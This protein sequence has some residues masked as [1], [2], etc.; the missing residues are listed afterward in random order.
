MSKIDPIRLEVMKNAFDAIADEMALMLMRA[1]YSP[2]VRDSMDYSTAIC[3]AQGQTL[4]QGVTT[5]M[6]LGSFYDAMQHLM[7][8]YEGD[9][10]PGDVFIGNDPYAAAG[11]HLPDIYIVEPIFFEGRLVAWTTTLAHHADVGGIVPGSNA[12]GAVEIYQEGLRLPFLKLYN[13]G[14]MNTAIWEILALNVR[15]PEMV[16]GDLRAQMAASKAGRKSFGE[17]VARYGIDE[18]LACAEELH[19]YAERLGRAEIRDLPNGEYHFT[20]HIDGL[21][22]TPEPIVIQIALTIHD[23]TISVD[24][25][26]SSPQVK[27]GV[28]TP[29]PFTKASVYT[30]LRSIMLSDIPNCHGFE[31]VVTV[32]APK[33]TVVNSVHPA[34]CG[35]RG[36]TGYRV[37]DGMFG[38][39]AQVVPDRVTADGMGGSTVPTFAGWHDGQAFV[40][41]ETVMGTWGASSAHDGQVGVP[42][43]GA[44]QANVPIE[45]IEASYP[46]RVK[47]YGIMPDTGGSGRYR[48]GNA[49]IREYEYL[50]E[51]EGLMSLRSDKRDFLPHGLEGGSE[52]TGPVNLL[53]QDGKET[54][55]P[56][57]VTEPYALK[58]GDVFRHISPSGGGFGPA[59]E[60]SLAEVAADVEAGLISAATAMR[61]Y[62]LPV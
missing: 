8:R 22:E 33:G 59:S 12:L 14:E 9:I 46:L 30:A 31:R 48:G 1:A 25:A 61:D 28:N 62:G 49:F 36:I 38:A 24:F 37:I 35:A 3:D 20:D 51:E 2:I 39:L 56:V 32:T 47:R 7:T 26:G 42:H 15:V 18:V 29:L 5:P 41:T 19:D 57:L 52:G 11:Q 6:H 17:L 34:P 13:Q 4:A 40:F 23:D 44:N 58:K 27:G 21:G 54:Q 55:L 53:I 45:M 50:G 60:R 16:Q 10:H 43:M